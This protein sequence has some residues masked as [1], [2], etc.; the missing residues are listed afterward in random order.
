MTL[1]ACEGLC[2]G[3]AS[4]AALVARGMGKPCVCGVT[5]MQVD[6]ATQTARIGGALVHEG[7]LIAIN[8]TTGEITVDDVPLVEPSEDPHMAEVLANFYEVLAWCDD[9]RTEGRALL[10]ASNVKVRAEVLVA[11]AEMDL[12]AGTTSGRAPLH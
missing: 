11:L 4:H 1:P 2:Q 8:G 10:E 5:A 7:D 3:K 12:A 9:V 6:L